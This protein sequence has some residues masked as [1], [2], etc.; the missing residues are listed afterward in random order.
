MIGL[1]GIEVS[2]Q[3]IEEGGEGGGSLKDMYSER[4]GNKGKSL[5]S[6]WGYIKAGTGVSCVMRW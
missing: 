1:E 6:G 2:F 5:L 3:G 4:V